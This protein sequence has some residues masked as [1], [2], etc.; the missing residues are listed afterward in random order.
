[1]VRLLFAPTGPLVSLTVRRAGVCCV[2]LPTD[3]RTLARTKA[4]VTAETRGTGHRASRIAEAHLTALVDGNQLRPE[5]FCQ[6][7]TDP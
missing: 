4:A 6:S 2:V 1:M 3:T 5:R 7:N